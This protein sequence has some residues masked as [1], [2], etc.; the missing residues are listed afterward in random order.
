MICPKNWNQ[1]DVNIALKITCSQIRHGGT[2]LYS[3]GLN[4]PSTPIFMALIA[5][6]K[7]SA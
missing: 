4:T 7:S 5:K 6:L 1:I 2:V 3:K